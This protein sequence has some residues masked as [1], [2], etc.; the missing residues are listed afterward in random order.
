MTSVLAHMLRRRATGVFWWAVGLAALVALLALAYPTVRG[1]SELDK[2]FADLPPGVAALLGLA[3]GNPL[4]SPAGYLD[5]QFFANL[6]PMSLLIF[7][8]GAAAWTVAG[9]EAAGTFELLVANPV[10]RTRVALARFAGLVALLAALA[11]ISAATLA[12]LAGPTGLT[13]GVS[14][15]RIVAATLAAA[16]LALV[17]ATVAYA[18]GATTGSRP[19]AIAVAAALAVAGYVAEGLSHQVPALRPTRFLNPWHWLLA[20]DPLRNGLTWR[21][22]LLPVA[23]VVVLLLAS[24]P[25]L[26]RRDLR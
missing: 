26:R 21:T 23:T 25:I 9:D 16:L 2:T 14:I 11:A 12:A 18:I 8:I 10:S 20:E 24:L 5:S 7:A 19:A 6:L 3:E 1:N 15:A 4:T 17:F 13:P 22:W